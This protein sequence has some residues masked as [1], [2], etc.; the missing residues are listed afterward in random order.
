MLNNINTTAVLLA[1][2]VAAATVAVLGYAAGRAFRRRRS[3]AV[4]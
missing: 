2:P 1:L 4:R 3:R